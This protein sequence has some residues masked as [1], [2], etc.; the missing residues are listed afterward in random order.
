MKR[1]R[2]VTLTLLAGLVLREADGPIVVGGSRVV[3]HLFR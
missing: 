3:P 1:S 2:S